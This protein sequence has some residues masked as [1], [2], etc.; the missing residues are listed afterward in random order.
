MTYG[1]H[2]G[3]K[4]AT[5]LDAQEA[6]GRCARRYQ[7]GAMKTTVVSASTGSMTVPDQ[8]M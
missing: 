8:S 3:S 5:E 2:G 4:N 7:S 1:P 6:G